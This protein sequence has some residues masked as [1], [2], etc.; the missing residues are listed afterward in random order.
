MLTLKRLDTLVQGFADSAFWHGSLCQLMLAANGVHGYFVKFHAHSYLIISRLK[1][2]EKLVAR[3]SGS[4]FRFC[5][6]L[7]KELRG[8][9][10]DARVARLVHEAFGRL[11]MDSGCH[12]QALQ[13]SPIP[14][15]DEDP[16]SQQKHIKKDRHANETL[17]RSTFAIGLTLSWTTV[18]VTVL[19]KQWVAAT[20]MCNSA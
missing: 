1:A 10:Y 4:G 2:S 16:R 15:S 20:M 12:D 7:Q 14:N 11:L 5:G 13:G 6:V 3:I 19:S 9:C 8:I 17:D 18:S